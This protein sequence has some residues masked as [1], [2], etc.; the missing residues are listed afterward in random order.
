MSIRKIALCFI[1]TAC[2]FNPSTMQEEETHSLNTY[3]VLATLYRIFSLNS[4]DNISF[5][6]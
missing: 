1:S 5:I 3:Y 4:T 6:N 2:A